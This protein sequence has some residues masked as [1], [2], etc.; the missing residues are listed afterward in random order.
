MFTH[1]EYLEVLK[2][3]NP[4]YENMEVISKYQG[5][6]KKI[7]IRCKLCGDVIEIGI[8]YSKKW[9]CRKCLEQMGLLQKNGLTHEEFLN[10]LKNN[11]SNH[12]NIEVLEE[13]VNAKTKIACRCKICDNIWKA[14][15]QVLC[16][17]N[18]GCPKCGI[19][20]CTQVSTKTHEYFIEEMKTKNPTVEIL[21]HYITSKDKVG[22]RCKICNY[23][24]NAT[25][26]DLLSRTKCPLC[27]NRVV[28][29]GYND[30]ATTHPD[31]ISYFNNSDDAYKFT[32]G[33]QRKVEVKCPDC[34]AI[35]KMAIN[36]LVKQGFSCDICSD[37]LSYPNKFL[38]NFVSQLP[39]QNIHYEYS[40]NWVGRYRYD[41]YFEYKGNS[42]IIEMDGGL[43]HGRRV[44]KSNKKDVDGAKRDKIKDMLAEQHGIILI[45][46]N[47]EKSDCTYISKNILNSQ[48]SDIFDLSNIDWELCDKNSQKNIIKEVCDYYQITPLSTY[49]LADL[50][51]LNIAT[52]RRYLKKGTLFNWCNYVPN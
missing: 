27:A 50:F 35:K 10:N 38:R 34:G 7:K 8:D 26:S 14:D 52:I 20:K 16:Y 42:Y 6:A 2:R 46:I 41:G 11:N 28:K 43:G 47:C 22:C 12:E 31:I 45:R 49:E 17:H 40:P 4:Y 18:G 37:K 23:E 21:S 25:P 30:I 19:Q 51:N 48:L 29:K 15:Y 9:R 13:Y 24:W 44:F 39:V 5:K 32:A 1:E 36:Q 3:K 33:S